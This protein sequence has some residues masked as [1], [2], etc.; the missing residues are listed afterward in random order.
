MSK[1]CSYIAWYLPF[2]AALSFLA[3]SQLDAQESNARAVYSYDIVAD[4][5]GGIWRI[6]TE[7]GEVS[8]CLFDTPTG[9][10]ERAITCSGWARGPSEEPRYR[11]DAENDELIP[12][13]DAAK[14]EARAQD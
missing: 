6:N 9:S 7:T 13:N 12:L 2:L 3:P 8:H 5:V 14:R 4:G 1:A 11:W 10:G